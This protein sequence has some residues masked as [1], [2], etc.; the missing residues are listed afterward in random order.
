VTI[1]PSVDLRKYCS[2][3]D[4]QGFSNVCTCEATTSGLELILRRSGVTEELSRLF[5]YWFAR[6]DAG[7]S[8]DSGAW[9]ANVMNAA[10]QHG[11]CDESL[12]DFNPALINTAPPADAQMQGAT[13]TLHAYVPLLSFADP[14][15]ENKASVMWERITA[16][17]Q[18]GNPVALHLRIG[19]QWGLIS[20]PLDSQTYPPIGPANPHGQNHAVLAVG[21]TPDYI[22]VKNSDGV[23]WG[24][25]G[26]GALGLAVL[27]DLLEAYA[28]RDFNGYNA[29]GREWVFAT[30][31][32]AE[33]SRQWINQRATLESAQQIIDICRQ[34]FISRSELEYLMA[35]YGWWQGLVTAFANGPGAGLN[36]VGWD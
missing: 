31:E 26:Y 17:L 12:W 5:L 6:L 10:Q 18:A 32:N 8:G 15:L 25:G 35:P 9:L 20:G 29:A 14:T 3:V 4:T 23:G 21:Y 24:D 22:I 33:A 13:Q 27:G 19:Q 2:V 28:L 36:W 11:V 34:Y 30:P 1:L 16:Q 7:L